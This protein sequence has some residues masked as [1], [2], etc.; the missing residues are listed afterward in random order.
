MTIG[1]AVSIWPILPGGSGAPVTGSAIRTAAPGS[2]GPQVSK[3]SGA[4]QSA[5]AISVLA[6]VWP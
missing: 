5:S 2:G 3:R 1:P 4:A 6:S